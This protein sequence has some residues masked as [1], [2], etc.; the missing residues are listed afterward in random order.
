MLPI[1][2]VSAAGVDRKRIA[3]R[4]EVTSPAPARSAARAVI[5]AAPVEAN[6]P[7]TT[8]VLAASYLWPSVAAPERFAP[9]LRG[10]FYRLRTD[11]VQNPCVMPISASRTRPQ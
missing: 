2:A 5:R 8:S 3:R 10:I 1:T 9:G 7:E 6:S 4:R 11:L